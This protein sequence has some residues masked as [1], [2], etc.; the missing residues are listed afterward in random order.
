LGYYL[1]E[2]SAP[3]HLSFVIGKKEDDLLEEIK[4]FA[5]KC[6]FSKVHVINK[7]TSYEICFG[8]RFL[9]GLF[10]CWFGDNA[11]TKK[12]PKFVFSASNKFKLNFLGAYINGDG[13]IEDKKDFLRIRIKTASKKLASD[14]MY[15][16]SHIGICAK[17]DH[18]QRGKCRKIAHNKKETGETTSYVIRIQNKEYL[19][20]LKE[21][22]SD[23]FK[24]RIE[25]RI[26]KMKFSQQFPP[27]ALPIEKLNF[28]EIIPKK[29]TFLDSIKKYNH[30]SKKKK[31]NISSKLLSEQSS[32]VYGFMQKMLNGDL[33]FDQIKS[34]TCTNYT[35]PVYDFSV[36]GAENFIGGF[37]GL[38][39]HNSGHGGREDLRDLI[40]L[41]NPEHVIPSHG[42]LKKLNAGAELAQEMGYRLQKNVHVAQ[43]G[44]T[45]SI[46]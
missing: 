20:S 18:I 16:F 22:L 27:E 36:P 40:R 43:N 11:R 25:T 26:P 14:L 41:L 17:F 46:K 37:G 45:I 9:R 1:A 33:F 42:D 5:E 15:L 28:N 19:S 12:I 44:R 38:M 31:V 6:F 29:N 13:H 21:F 7:E 34:I 32:A 2:G 23:K 8:A 39:L 4:S 35:G 24:S 3:R 30:C 10:K